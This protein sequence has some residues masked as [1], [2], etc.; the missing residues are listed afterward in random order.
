[1][2]SKLMSSL[3]LQEV[4]STVMDFCCIERGENPK[5]ERKLR[6]CIGEFVKV[7]LKGRIDDFVCT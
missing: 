5:D 2:Y 6:G 1:M 4:S 3:P 7:Q